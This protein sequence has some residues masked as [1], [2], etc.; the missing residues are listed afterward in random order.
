MTTVR[1]RVVMMAMMMQ[2]R[3]VTVRSPVVQR[4]QRP[5]TATVPETVA[6]AALTTRSSPVA[7]A[8][9]LTVPVAVTTAVQSSMTA[10]S[11]AV[12]V[13]VAVSMVAA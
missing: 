7:E 6:K 1:K 5:V 10:S 8:V 9:A 4:R 2:V 3:G 12:T 11:V 13:P